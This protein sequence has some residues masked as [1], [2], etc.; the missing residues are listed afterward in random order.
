MPDGLFKRDH[1]DRPHIHLTEEYELA[2]LTGRFDVHEDDPVDDE[3]LEAIR[4]VGNSE[5]EVENYLRARG[6]CSC[7][8]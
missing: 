4:T 2:Y 6:A 5:R 3:L 7:W 1:C 8:R